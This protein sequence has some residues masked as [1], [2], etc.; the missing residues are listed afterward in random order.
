MNFVSLYIKKHGTILNNKL[1]RISDFKDLFKKAGY[2]LVPSHYELKDPPTSEWISNVTIVGTQ[3]PRF[4]IILRDCWY[5]IHLDIK[6]NHNLNDGSIKL[7][8]LRIDNEIKRLQSLIDYSD[9][10]FVP[11]YLIK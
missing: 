7:K 6:R 1:G 10:S 9:Y 2:R 5:S 3:F 11:N 8:G 4:H